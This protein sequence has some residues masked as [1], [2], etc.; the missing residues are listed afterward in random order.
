V[1]AHDARHALGNRRVGGVDRARHD[2]EVVADQRGQ[3]AGRAVP[4]VRLADAADRLD[5]RRVV[6]QH[7]AATVDLG[8][9]KPRQ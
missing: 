2:V 4:A 3:E 8:V 7:A 6:E 5:A 1:D 9:D